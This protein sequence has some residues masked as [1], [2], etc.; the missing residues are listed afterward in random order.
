VANI[1]ISDI[2]ERAKQNFEHFCAHAGMNMSTAF[3]ILVNIAIGLQGELPA[4][5][6]TLQG[7]QRSA[8]HEFIALNNAITN[9]EL[10]TEDYAEFQSGKYKIQFKEGALDL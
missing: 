8:V 5:I 3:N 4:E 1:T 6:N 10:S 7:Q 2:D 9:D